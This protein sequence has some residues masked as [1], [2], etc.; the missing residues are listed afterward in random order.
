MTALRAG[1]QD[2][3]VDHMC[4]RLLIQLNEFGKIEWDISCIV[5]TNEHACWAASTAR[6]E[7]TWT[8]LTNWRVIDD[9]ASPVEALVWWYYNGKN[10]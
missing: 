10:A 3:T 7:G 2:S 4:E 1:Q 9:T 6:K 8:N 5:A